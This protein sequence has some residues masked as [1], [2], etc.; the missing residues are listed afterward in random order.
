M[1]MLVNAVLISGPLLSCT[2]W[3]VQRWF[4]DLCIH[5]WVGWC[6]ADFW[7]SAFTHM[8]AIAVLISESS[9]LSSTCWLVQCWFLDLCFYK[10]QCSSGFSGVLTNTNCRPVRNLV[11]F[12]PLFL[13]FSFI[14]DDWGTHSSLTSAISMSFLSH[15]IGMSDI[16][17]FVSPD[18]SLCGWLG[19]KH[20]L[21]N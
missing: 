9:L 5:A 7:F 13:I 20:Q 2:C 4:Q 10:V 8:L 18:V 21:T 6:N 12:P 3:L 19:L 16:H 17:T 1:H 11:N 15:D 14:K